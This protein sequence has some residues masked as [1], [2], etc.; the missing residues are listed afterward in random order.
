VP[1]TL[2]PLSDCKLDAPAPHASPD[3]HLYLRI[4]LDLRI[5]AVG[6]GFL[7]QR[8]LLT[9][10]VRNLWHFLFVPLDLRPNR[11]NRPLPS[12]ATTAAAVIS[13]GRGIGFVVPRSQIER[14]FC[15]LRKI[16]GI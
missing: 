10:A 7:G 6:D 2:T 3:L 13:R 16:L 9:D 4:G 5:G 12:K 1:L 8:G 11:R 14:D 15:L